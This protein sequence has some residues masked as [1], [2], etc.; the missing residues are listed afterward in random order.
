MGS[1]WINIPGA[2]GAGYDPGPLAQ[3]TYFVRCAKSATCTTWLESNVVVIT[4]GNIAVADILPPGPVCT[5][6]PVTFFAAPNQS[7][8]TYSWNFGPSATPST[9]TV[10]NPTVSFGQ[11][12]VFPISLTVVRNGC[13]STDQESIAVSSN[14]A[15]CSNTIQLPG[16]GHGQAVLA[17][18]QFTVFPN[19]FSSGLTVAWDK[20]TE[21]AVSV[22]LFSVEGKLLHAGRSANGDRQYEANLENLAPGV[23]LLRLQSEDGQSG[24]FKLVKE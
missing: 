12:G 5:N 10:P 13:T 23:Y 22:R 3:T 2:T 8:A 21:G 18:G 7:G 19:P 15:Y 11:A 16:G 6:L 17:D 24:V 4:V 14:P 20:E 1:N 9:A